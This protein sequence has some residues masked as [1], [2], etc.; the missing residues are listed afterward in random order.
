VLIGPGMLDPEGAQQLAT[1]VLGHVEGA[2]ILLDA[3]TLP[4]LGDSLP[5]LRR[6]AGRLVVTPHAGE[7]AGILGRERS[8]IEADPL[9]AAREAAG[10]L[11]A[12][13]IMKGA[14]T[15]I[16]SP[17]GR[18]WLFDGGNVGLATGGSGDVLAGCLAALLARGASPIGAALW[19]VY[20]H[21]AA[22]E[23]LARASGPIGYLTRDLAAQFPAILAD[24]DGAASI[25]ARR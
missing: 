7:M 1:A 14:T 11:Q 18:A 19:G 13:V 15:H 12:V 23:R 17:E 9:G 8:A 25:R 4:G 16:V 3:A 2:A 22:G 24:L 5:A 21:G 6:H 20:M 10:R